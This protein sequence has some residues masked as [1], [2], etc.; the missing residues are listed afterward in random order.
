MVYSA[1]IGSGTASREGRKGVMARKKRH[2]GEADIATEVS[3]VLHLSA[4]SVEII[5]RS[6]MPLHASCHS[7][8]SYLL[9]RGDTYNAGGFTKRCKSAHVHSRYLSMH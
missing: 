9:I 3:Y 5:L 1:P 2:P 8:N 7:G 6:A 4:K